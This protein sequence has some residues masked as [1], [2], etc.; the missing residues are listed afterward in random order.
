MCKCQFSIEIFN[1]FRQFTSKFKTPI[2]ISKA[3]DTAFACPVPLSLRPRS[4]I[5]LQFTF[6]SQNVNYFF[7]KAKTSTST[8]CLSLSM[9]ISSSRSKQ[10]ISFLHILKEFHTIRNCHILFAIYFHSCE[11]CS[12]ISNTV[13]TFLS[14]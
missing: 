10:S 6:L 13:R 8:E 11:Y 9:S 3:P 2:S 7:Q 14:H 5:F 1:S 4:H 12:C